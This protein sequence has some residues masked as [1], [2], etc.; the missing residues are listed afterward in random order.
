[1]LLGGRKARFPTVPLFHYA[2]GWSLSETLDYWHVV[3]GW[4]ESKINLK[5]FRKTRDSILRHEHVDYCCHGHLDEMSMT[6]VY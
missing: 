5:A 1:M 3:V 2:V 4:R 6:A